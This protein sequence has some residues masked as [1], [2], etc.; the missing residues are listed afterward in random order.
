MADNI[1]IRVAFLVMNG[2]RI[3]ARATA[4]EIRDPDLRDRA[5]AIVG[6]NVAS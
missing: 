2:Q 3:T 1:L 5:M 4:M 6:N